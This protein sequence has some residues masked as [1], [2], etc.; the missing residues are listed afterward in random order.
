MIGSPTI[1]QHA[2]RVM[3]AEKHRQLIFSMKF[4]KFVLWAKDEYTRL[5]SKEKTVPEDNMTLFL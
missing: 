1:C 2:H 5:Y 3:I 4:K